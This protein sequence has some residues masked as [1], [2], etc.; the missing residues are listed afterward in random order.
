M[1]HVFLLSIAV[2]ASAQDVRLGAI[3][4]LRATADYQSVGW[5]LQSRQYLVGPSFE[6]GLPL[7]IGFEADAI[8]SRLGSGFVSG[9][10]PSTTSISRYRT[11][12][13]EFPLLIKRKLPIPLVRPFVVAGY[14]PRHTEETGSF[15][16]ATSGFDTTP[17]RR[18]THGLVVGGGIEAGIGRLR[19]TPQV[20][21]TRWNKPATEVRGSQ[22]SYIRSEQNQVQILV[23]ISWKIH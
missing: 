22:G 3:G 13:W 6:I 21:Y 4:G 17:E 20:R 2:C 18:W 23:G 1:S 14:A 9:L 11:N 12:S 5:T 8:Y 19:F 15:R 10:T 7:G 16:S